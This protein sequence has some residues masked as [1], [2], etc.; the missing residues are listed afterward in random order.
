MKRIE[1]I[2]SMEL[3]EA[4]NKWVKN[5][6]AEFEPCKEAIAYVTDTQVER[7]L[8]SVQLVASNVVAVCC[9]GELLRDYKDNKLDMSKFVKILM[10]YGLVT[11]AIYLV[12]MLFHK[13]L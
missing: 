1:L 4:Y 11:I 12:P 7:V 9:I 13:Y 6:I 5:G 3:T 10:K 2:P 8:E